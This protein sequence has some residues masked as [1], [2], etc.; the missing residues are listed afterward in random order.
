[1]QR[2]LL[3]TLAAIGSHCPAAL[4]H[5]SMLLPDK[6]SVKKGEA[7]ALTYQWGH[8][9]EHEL[10]DAPKPE[11]LFVL[12]PDGKRQDLLKSLEKIDLPTGEGKKVAAYRLRFTP[13]ARGDYT[14]VLKTPPFW[15]KDEEEYF[16]DTVKVVLH[17]QAQKGWDQAAGEDFEVAPLTRPYGLQPG[18]VFQAQ[19]ESRAGE[20]R[21]TV[22]PRTRPVEIERYN[23]TPPKDLP[24]DEF[25]TR[26][27]KA[28]RNGVFT[29]T[30]TD[31]G[32]WC[33][34]A[35]RPKGSHESFPLL[36]RSTLWVFVDEKPAK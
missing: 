27:T 14:F 31:A 21:P 36:Q 33:L 29:G 17:V 20:A 5:Y 9:F 11:R 8:P 23:A 3:L 26:T 4:A 24:P 19:L 2:L 15:M 30:L 32:W 28:D 12:S 35:A 18:M 16:Q 1:M 25:I 6:A 7:V 34:T 22:I 10:F 13:D